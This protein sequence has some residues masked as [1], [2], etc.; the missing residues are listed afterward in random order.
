MRRYDTDYRFLKAGAIEMVIRRFVNFHGLKK[1]LQKAENL[2]TFDAKISDEPKRKG[3]GRRGSILGESAS[4]DVDLSKSIRLNN[5]DKDLRAN[6]D[7]KLFTAKQNAF[8]FNFQAI[9][10]GW[11][12]E[13]RKCNLGWIFCWFPL[14]YQQAIF[15]KWGDY[16]G[17]SNEKAWDVLMYARQ[18][19]STSGSGSFA[20]HLSVERTIKRLG[21]VKKVKPESQEGDST[22]PMQTGAPQENYTWE[23]ATA[24]CGQLEQKDTAQ[25]WLERNLVAKWMDESKYEESPY[26]FFFE[27][28]RRDLFFWEVPKQ[29][30]TACDSS[31]NP[32][33]ST[34]FAKVV[35]LLFFAVLKWASIAI[36]LLFPLLFLFLLFFVPFCY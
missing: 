1:V 10:H 29:F 20:D 11:I 13:A 25:G 14:A 5:E 15:N 18:K 17:P 3:I 31:F 12:E 4:S 9:L 35:M 22:N 21:I 30:R 8:F 27:Q 24:E 34:R 16:R 33:L 32:D 19:E 23:D 36:Q 6:D 26:S 28:V 2:L 7:T